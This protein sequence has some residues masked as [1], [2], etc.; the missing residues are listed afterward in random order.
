MIK[1]KSYRMSLYI[2]LLNFS[3]IQ[4][5][6]IYLNF[7]NEQNRYFLY[8]NNDY[9]LNISLFNIIFSMISLVCT[10]KYRKLP[11]FYLYITHVI[12]SLN[13]GNFLT[14]L[15]FL[16]FNDYFVLSL[17][18]L[19][20]YSVYSLLLLLDIWKL[21]CQHFDINAKISFISI[22]FIIIA[23]FIQKIIGNHIINIDD[24]T[25]YSF[26][27]FGWENVFYIVSRITFTIISYL[28]IYHRIP[29]MKIICDE[30]FLIVDYMNYINKIGLLENDNNLNESLLTRNN[31]RNKN[32]NKLNL[33]INDRDT[34]D[35]KNNYS[36]PGINLNMH[37]NIGSN[38]GDKD[39]NK[40][41]FSSNTIIDNNLNDFNLNSSYRRISVSE[42]EKD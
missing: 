10:F 5:I 7:F 25:F 29:S 3:I 26:T 36:P 9:I 40:S 4:F 39:E 22:I 11:K 14:K 34:D 17:F 31:D 33:Q 16:I 1:H 27:S 21:Y 24:K 18:N 6:S 38:E 20:F 12:I 19:M 35:D 2:V 32:K 13:V 8:Y 28:I 37:L 42:S 15:F 41:K 30:T 23:V